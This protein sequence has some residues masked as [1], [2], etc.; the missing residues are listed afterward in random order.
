VFAPFNFLD[1]T[2]IGIRSFHAFKHEFGVWRREFA[3]QGHQYEVLLEYRHLERLMKRIAPYSYRVLKKDCLDL[4]PKLYQKRYF[5]LSK[6]QQAV[7]NRLRDDYI[8]ELSLGGKPLA[9]IVTLV[10]TR[11]LRLQQIACGHMPSLDPK[12]PVTPIHPNARL[13]ALQALVEEWPKDTQAIIWARFTPDIDQ[14][15]AWL[16]PAAVRYDGKVSDDVRAAN[17]KK[18]QDGD[19]RFFVGNPKAG[20]KGL[21]LTAATAVVFYSNDFSLETRLQAEDRAHRI[22]QQ[23]PVTYVDLVAVDTVDEKIVTSLRGKRKLSDF[24]TGDTPED[25]L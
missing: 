18:F 13:N 9:T 19:A 15:C 23:H 25:W 6:E 24:L 16:G 12:A 1:P 21:T 8:L 3:G 10:L 11:I 5:E 7:Y 22:G 4:P 17:K 2:I 14:I 20:G